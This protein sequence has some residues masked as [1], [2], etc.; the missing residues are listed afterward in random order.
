[1]GVLFALVSRWGGLKPQ[2]RRFFAAWR[3]AVR[4]QS[5]HVTE[6]AGAAATLKR[7]GIT[8]VLWAFVSDGQ[9]VSTN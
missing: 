7:P 3:G 8:D 2:C 4:K 6:N 5:A 9:F 1:M